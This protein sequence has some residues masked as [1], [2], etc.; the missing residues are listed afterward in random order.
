M[1][2]PLLQPDGVFPQFGGLEVTT[3]STALSALTDAVLYLH[4]YRYDS[5][6]A[7]ASRII[8][9]ASLR[10]ILD[11]FS[12]EGL[13]PAGRAR[14]PGRRRHRRAG[15]A[16]ELR[17]RVQLV[18]VRSPVRAVRVGAGR[19]RPGPR[20]RRGLRGPRAGPAQRPPLPPRA[21]R[22]RRAGISRH[23]T[24]SPPTRSTSVISPAR[25]TPTPQPRSTTS[26]APVP[27][28]TSSAS[29]PSPGCGR[30][31]PTPS[32]T[33]SRPCSPTGPPRPPARRPSPPTTAS[34]PTCCCTPIGAPTA[35]SSMR[36]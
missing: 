25:A 14:R 34:R 6:D 19:P 20:P 17:R 28:T 35:S 23:A 22:S 9:V 16:A 33:R 12:A 3:S 1:L 18:A 13:P 36:C 4:E 30:S 8:A 24:P 7:Y 11:A 29:T 21:S 10:D 5:A 26:S 32:T 31:C 2:Q 27:A 15:A